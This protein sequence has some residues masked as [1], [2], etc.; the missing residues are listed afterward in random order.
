MESVRHDICKILVSIINDPDIKDRIRIDAA[1]I[2]L[3]I[4]WGK[5]FVNSKISKETV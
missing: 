4:G 1:A 3:Q 5:I 2:L